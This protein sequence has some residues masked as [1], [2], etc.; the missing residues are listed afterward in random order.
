[1]YIHQP[2]FF[3]LHNFLSGATGECSYNLNRRVIVVYSISV[4]RVSSFQKEIGS[5]T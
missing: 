4:Y 3:I 2:L 5:F 1:M